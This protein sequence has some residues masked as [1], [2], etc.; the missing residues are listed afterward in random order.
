M[1]G[2]NIMEKTQYI[3]PICNNTNLILR[4]EASYVYS[5]VI[6]S[7]EPGLKNEEEFMSFLYDKREQKDTRTFVECVT[8]GTQYPYTFL[9]GILE[10]K[11]Q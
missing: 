11:M 4:Y 5:Y 6:D 9:N 8:C 1:K 2:N 7:D 3:C 10:Q